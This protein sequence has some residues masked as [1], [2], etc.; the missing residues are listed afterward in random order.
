MKI[1]PKCGNKYGDDAQFCNNCGAQLAFNEPAVHENGG[2]MA[3]SIVTLLLCTI[4]GIVAI[5][6]T[7]KAN[8]ALLRTEEEAALKTAKVWNIVGDVIGVLFLIGTIAQM[9]A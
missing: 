9:N 7:N 2:M 5:V 4:P 1:C 8:K 6:Y 3:W